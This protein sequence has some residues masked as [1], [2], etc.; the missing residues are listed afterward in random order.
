MHLKVCGQSWLKATNPE[1]QLPPQPGDLLGLIWEILALPD[2]Q[3]AQHDGPPERPTTALLGG[4]EEGR[5]EGNT[6]HRTD[7]PLQSIYCHEF[8]NGKMG[9]L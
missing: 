5:L 3:K 9:H 2:S 7:Q 8:L 6:L 1:L 4:A